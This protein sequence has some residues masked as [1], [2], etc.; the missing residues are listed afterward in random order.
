MDKKFQK[1]T[2]TI[3]K[4]IDFFPE[5]DPIKN[6]SKEKALAIL[7][8]LVLIC[9]NEGW[10]SFKD[11]F[12]AEKEKAKIEIL[13]DIE[14]LLGYFEV[15]K[16]QGWVS[17]ANC[18]IICN[19]Y[20]KIKKQIHVSPASVPPE[21][22]YGEAKPEAIKEIKK[23]EKFTARQTEIIK[24]LTQNQKA[25]VMDLQEVLPNV[26]KRTIRRDLDELL[27]M[28]KIQRV[29]QFNQVFYRIT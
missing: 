25:Q 18:L 20:E 28:G 26:T 4:L 19:E 22:D 14:I 1:L 8:N 16:T 5:A 2:S 6:K 17:V 15:A 24:Y 3:Y 11:Y 12:S 29:G 27:K 21:R 10:M 9:E 7:E 23:E 13:K